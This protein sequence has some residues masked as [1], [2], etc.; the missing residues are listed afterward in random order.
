MAEEVGSPFLPDRGA[1]TVRTEAGSGPLGRIAA[2]AAFAL[3]LPVTGLAAAL[4]WLMLGSPFLFRQRRSGFGGRTF[5]L[6]KLRTMSDRR[7]G[8]GV[9]LPDGQRL[10]A[11]GRTIRRFRLD[12]VPQLL[13][14]ARG[15]MSWIGPRPLLPQTVAAMGERGRMRGF[16]PPGLTGWAQVNGNTMLSQ[17]EKTAL[18]LWYAHHASARL[19][20]AILFLTAATVLRGERRH[21][22][23][24]ADALAF[25]RR[26][27]RAGPR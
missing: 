24:I 14:I 3:L 10:N 23:R 21:E 27:D 12:E 16:V 7:D 25:L 22:T 26:L 19:D 8:S 6:V 17:E 18:D 4:I 2:A 20:L 15:D 13:S 11:F 9:P 1:R 5:T